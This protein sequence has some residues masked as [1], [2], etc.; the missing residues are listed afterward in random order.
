MCTSDPSDPEDSDGEAPPA[1]QQIA[2]ALA[3]LH[4]TSTTEC[5]MGILDQTE[6]DGIQTFSDKG[7]GCLGKNSIVCSERF[8]PDDL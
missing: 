7:C 8:S 4:P 1:G 2:H 5:D 3:R 6:H